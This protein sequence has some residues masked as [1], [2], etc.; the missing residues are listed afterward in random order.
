MQ[1]QINATNVAW[2]RAQNVELLD[3]SRSLAS[4]HRTITIFP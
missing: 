2:H 1:F 3:G 4:I